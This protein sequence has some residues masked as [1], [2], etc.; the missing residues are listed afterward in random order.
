MIVVS[1]DPTTYDEQFATKEKTLAALLNAFDAPQLETFRSPPLHFR[2]RAEFK[3]WHEGDD[4]HYAIFNNGRGNR[5][6]FVE[7]FPT[8]SLAINKLMPILKNEFVAC[9]LLRHRLFQ[10]EF[11]STLAGDM[12]VT[13]IYHK[14][15]TEE[16]EATA[17]ALSD[18]LKIKI[19]GR[20]KKQKVI[21]QTDYVEEIFNLNDK[22]RLTYRQLE[23]CFSQPNGHICQH[24][25]DWAASVTHLSQSRNTDLLELY[26]GNGNF[27]VALA[28]NFNTV[29]AT[30]ISKPLTAAAILNCEKN[31][32]VNVNLVRM[33][34]ED[35]SSALQG[36]REFRRLKDIDLNGYD[37]ST[38]FVDPPRAGLD[39]ETE[40][41]VQRFENILYVSCNPNTLTKNLQTL[42]QTHI[43]KRAAFFDQFPY[44]D[45]ME[46]GVLLQKK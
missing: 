42:T 2:L 16:W 22:Q 3:I 17:R 41:M 43:I 14:P 19:I 4:S 32:V 18:K 15:L 44:T 37:F 12:L 13:M 24:M 6:S 9:E 20:S 40:K 26:C 29:L 11:L 1:P 30:E 34:A 10:I 33:S 38:V 45:H 25:L 28:P 23:G 21:L 27:T 36:E 39:N 31:N 46:C 35:I 8:A 7:S 5:P